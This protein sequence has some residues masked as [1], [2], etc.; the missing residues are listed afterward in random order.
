MVESGTC[1]RLPESGTCIHLAESGTCIHLAESGSCFD[2]VVRE[3][4]NRLGICQQRQPKESF[5]FEV[6]ER[7]PAGAALA[8]ADEPSRQPVNC[9]GSSDGTSSAL[10]TG[11]VPL[12]C[13]SASVMLTL[14]CAWLTVR[15]ERCSPRADHEPGPTPRGEVFGSHARRLGDG[16]RATLPSTPAR[17]RTLFLCP[18]VPFG[19]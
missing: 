12:T 1:I 13:A 14:A 17:C 19:S 5:R 8:R 10:F 15:T 7:Q 3:K 2:C 9:N 16:S 18:H 6:R 11:I 4:S